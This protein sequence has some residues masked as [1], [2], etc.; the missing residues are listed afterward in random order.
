MNACVVK[1]DDDSA[2]RTLKFIVGVLLLVLGCMIYLSWRS[3]RTNIY[4][5]CRSA[6]LDFFLDF[7]RANVGTY[8]PATF[9]TE[10]LPDGLFCAAYMF[11]MDSIWDR[12]RLALRLFMV[13]FMPTVAIVHEI[14]QRFGL[15]TGTFDPM[16]LV[17]YALP[18][19]IYILIIVTDYIRYNHNN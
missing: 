10:S 6:G 11:V 4:L 14:L 9:V 15:M 12:S 19:F 8:R 18:P 13:L 17:C 1:N 5:W 3:E 7:L 2:K 16:D